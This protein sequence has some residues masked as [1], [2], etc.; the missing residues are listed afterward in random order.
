[1]N[2]HCVCGRMRQRSF[3][4]GKASE[5]LAFKTNQTEWMCIGIGVDVCV[6]ACAY[7]FLC[8]IV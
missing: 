1:M 3:I 2:G 5:S 4:H 7:L 8:G 6:C